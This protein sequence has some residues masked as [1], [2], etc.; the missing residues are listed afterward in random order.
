MS[1]FD[2][3]ATQILV[4]TCVNK[5]TSEKGSLFAVEEHVWES[6]NLARIGVKFD[7]KQGEI[8]I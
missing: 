3:G 4:Y 7:V 1:L 5:K 6:G 8:L 2:L